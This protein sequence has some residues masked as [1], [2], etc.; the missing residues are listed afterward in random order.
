MKDK[1]PQLSIIEQLAREYDEKYRNLEKLIAQSAPEDIPPQLAAL[2]EQAS[3]CFR[4]AQM[5]LFSLPEI[6]ASDTRDFPAMTALFRSF[7]ELRILFHF[8]YEHYLP[9]S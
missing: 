4:S 9:R 1:T 2:A 8:L 3:N 7:D 6:L 5:D